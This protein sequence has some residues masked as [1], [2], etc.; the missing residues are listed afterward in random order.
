MPHVHTLD[1][2]PCDSSCYDLA[3]S[4]LLDIDVT[5]SDCKHAL[6]IAIQHAIEDHLR[7]FEEEPSQ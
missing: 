5:C 6:A 7:D 4:F 2:T 1:E 3:E